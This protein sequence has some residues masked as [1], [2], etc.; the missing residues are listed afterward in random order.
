MLEMMSRDVLA[1]L[2]RGNGLRA[3]AMSGILDDVRPT[4]SQTSSSALHALRYRGPTAG[5]RVIFP[6]VASANLL[7]SSSCCFLDP[8]AS[9]EPRACQSRAHPHPTLVGTPHSMVVTKQ[10]VLAGL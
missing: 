6:N 8:R 3:D 2:L 1:L 5:E 10:P 9:H 7:E 4:S